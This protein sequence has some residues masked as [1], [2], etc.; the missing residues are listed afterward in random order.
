M[1]SAKLKK[2][3]EIAAAIEA[4]EQVARDLTY[5]VRNDQKTVGFRAGDDNSAF[6]KVDDTYQRAYVMK[7]IRMTE[8]QVEEL[9]KEFNAL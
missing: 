4:L 7:I 2:A 6:V 1:D 9:K 8:E 5:S 3:N